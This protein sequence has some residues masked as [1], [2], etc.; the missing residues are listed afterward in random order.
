[1]ERKIPLPSW[2]LLDIAFG[3]TFVLAG[4]FALSVLIKPFLDAFF[5]L[6]GKFLIASVIQ[7]GLFLSIVFFIVLVRYK[8]DITHLGVTNNNLSP[9][10]LRKGLT[11]GIVLFFLVLFSGV[12][13]S[14]LA[15]IEPKP[16]PFAD[17]FL[18]AET[19][20]QKVIPFI[21]GGL[22]APLGE[23]VFFRGFAYPVF[24]NRFG[25]VSGIIVTSL[26]FAVLHFDTVR[27]IPIALGGAGLAWLYET[28]GML[29]VP[30]IAHSIWNISML[31]L[32]LIA[33]QA[34][35]YF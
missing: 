15:P 31:G 4:S 7:T 17:L 32:L 1:M 26:F 33:S 30:M 9:E 20:F 10:V 22:F 2:N 24:R 28:T 29:I 23:E 16:Q 18:N 5:S 11:G 21:I 34:E 27:F 3:I 13:V 25:V 14:A 19:G 8:S 35:V 12:V 6:P